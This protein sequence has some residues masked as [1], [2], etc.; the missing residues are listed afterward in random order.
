MKSVLTGSLVALALSVSAAAAQDS[1][2]KSQTKVDGDDAHAVVMR[3][4]LQQTAAGNGFLLLGAVSAAGDD[5]KSKSKVKTDVDDDKTTVKGKSTTKIDSD[6]D[7]GVATSGTAAAYGVTPRQG[8]DLATHAGEEVEISAVMID[9]RTGGDKD[10]DLKIKDKTKVDRE[11][12]PD[13]KVQSKTK[14]DIA[15][16]PV[17]QLMAMSVKSLG[18]ACSAQ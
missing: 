8:V 18:R 4:C 17:A 10:A 6:D 15:R 3:G 1:T 14:A 2:V 16:G 12:A 11:D 7:H 13:S 9:A 5:L